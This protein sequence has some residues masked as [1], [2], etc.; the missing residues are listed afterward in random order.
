MICTAASIS[1]CASCAASSKPRRAAT[2]LALYKAF[3]GRTSG[4]CRM[5]EIVDDPREEA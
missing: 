3:I 1:A 5:Q 4:A 2:L